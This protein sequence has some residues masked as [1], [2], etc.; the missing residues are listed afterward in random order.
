MGGAR[1]VNRTHEGGQTIDV[2]G[3]G[4]GNI[5]WWANDGA[6]PPTFSCSV[7]AINGARDLG[8]ADF[9][10]DGDVDILEDGQAWWKNDGDAHFTR[11]ALPGGAYDGGEAVDFDNDGDMDVIGYDREAGRLYILTNDGDGVFTYT[12]TSAPWTHD[13]TTGDFDNDGDIDVATGS[14]YGDVYWFEAPTW[15]QHHIAGEADWLQAYAVFAK[16]YNADGNLDILVSVLDASPHTHGTRW[17]TGDGAGGFSMGDTPVT[18]TTY[19]EYTSVDMYVADL[20]WDAQ[21]DILGIAPVSPSG[22]MSWIWEHPDNYSMWF[23]VSATGQ[24]TWA[25]MYANDLNSDGNIDALFAT[26]YGNGIRYALGAGDG[27]F[28]QTGF[29]PT[30]VYAAAG[31]YAIDLDGDYI[32]L[33]KNYAGYEE[34]GDITTRVY[35]ATDRWNGMEIGG[36]NTVGTSAHAYWYHSSDNITFQKEDLGNVSF[37]SYISLAAAPNAKY[38]YVQIVLTTTNDQFSPVVAH[39]TLYETQSGLAYAILYDAN[40]NIV[41]HAQATIQNTANGLIVERWKDINDGII[42]FSAAGTYQIA[43]RTFDGVF[44]STVTV[45]DSQVANITIPLYYNL[46]IHPLDQTGT[47]LIDVFCGLSEYTPLNPMSFWGYSMSGSQSVPITN[48]S[49]FAMCDLYAEK[50]GYTAYEATALNWTSRS[51]MIKDYRHD[52]LL[53]AEP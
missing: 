42:E 45:N 46:D 47:P 16:D 38:G 35:E 9:D 48:C 39:I 27:G 17:Y 37:G 49:G 30:S 53:E 15:T 11:H 34:S 21:P 20:N 22:L 33:R 25:N 51:A 40:Q 44:V 23:V 52:V 1:H 18:D 32:I 50:G 13:L 29:M 10:G 28:Y 7:L 31:T 4:S 2:I 41:Q 6:D 36:Y 12:Y 3:S 8:A 5:Y 26:S 43:V 14:G 24:M 19:Q